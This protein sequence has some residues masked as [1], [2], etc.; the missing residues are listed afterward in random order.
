M[1][2]IRFSRIGK[3]KHP[4]YRIIISEKTKDTQATYHELLGHYNPHTKV[5]SFKGDRIQHWVKMGATMSDSVYNL[6]LNHKVIDG[7]KKR[8]VVNISGRR[9]KELADKHEK[10][11]KDK[12]DEK[13]A[14]PKTTSPA[15]EDKK[16]ESTA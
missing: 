3:R 5:A 7:D 16:E 12:Q 1:L 11:G 8:S 2:T 6:L 9:K 15:E 10:D 14:E 13:A 4:F